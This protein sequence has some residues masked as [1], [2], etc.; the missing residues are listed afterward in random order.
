MIDLVMKSDKPSHK[1]KNL[2]L[3]TSRHSKKSVFP[4]TWITA[5]YTDASLIIQSYCLLKNEVALDFVNH[6]VGNLVHISSCLVS[7]IDFENPM[8]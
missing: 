7:K 2:D 4:I 6:F 3:I 1:T 5:P 8:R